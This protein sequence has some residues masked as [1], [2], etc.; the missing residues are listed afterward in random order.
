MP[1]KGWTCSREQ[2]GQ[3]SM[4]PSFIFVIYGSQQMWLRLKMDLPTSKI[5]IRNGYSH[6]K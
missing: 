6:F 4:L 2:A 1:V 5:Q 3:E